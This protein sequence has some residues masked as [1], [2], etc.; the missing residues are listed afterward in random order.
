MKMKVD[1]IYKIQRRYPDHR[2]DYKAIATRLGDREVIYYTLKDNGKRSQGVETYT[3]KNFIVGSNKLSHSRNY[4]IS[5]VPKT[6][7]LIVQQA[8]QIHRAA[9]WSNAKR[10]DFN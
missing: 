7:K 8:K 4:P 2:W 1:Q 9:H 5:K 10:V 6:L 3:G